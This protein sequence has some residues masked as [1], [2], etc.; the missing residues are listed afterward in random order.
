MKRKGI[1]ILFAVDTSKSML[2]QDVK[3]D[4]L[5]RAKLAVTDLVNKL[6]GDRVGLIAFAGGAFLQSPLTLDYDAFRQS[7][8]ALDTTVIPRGGTDVASAIHEAQRTFGTDSKNQKILVLITD[9][10]D[11]EAQGVQAAGAAAKEGLKIFAVGVGSTTG[12]LIPVPSANGGTEFVKDATGKL[13]KSHLDEKSLKE[14]AAATGGLYE[15]LGQSGEGL[16]RIYQQ[17]LAPLPKQE[18]MSRRQ[19]IYVERFQWPLLAGLACLLLELLIGTRK[20]MGAAAHRFVPIPA[21]QRM[22]KLRP[23]VA[24]ALGLMA[25]PAGLRASPQSAEKAYEKGNFTG[26]QQQYA[27]AARKNP[28]TPVLQFNLGAAAY[29]AGQ[30]DEAATAF[31]KTL[32]GEKIG[33]QQLAYYN[34]GN[35][36][37]RVGQKSVT[38]KPEETIKSWQEALQSYEAALKLK[39]DDADAKF[40]RDLVKKKLEEL[41]KKQQQK[42]DE[43]QKKNQKDQKDQQQ[44][45]DQQQGQGNEDQKK[46]K[47]QSKS[48]ERNQENEKPGSPEKDKQ[49]ESKPE[50]PQSPGNKDEKGGKPD[51]QQA[52]GSPDEKPKDDKK[53]GDRQPQLAKNESKQPNEQT[54]PGESPQEEER[55]RPGEMSKQEAKALLDSLQKG[56]RRLPMSSLKDES[57]ASQEEPR[58][59]DW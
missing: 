46:Q 44:K 22:R 34:L 19:K 35:T 16:E 20:R 53:P 6:D 48:G 23:A 49:Q 29:K 30:Y 57:R 26:S 56:D 15:P 13:V 45:S 17:A 32:P 2:A 37:F 8:D 3:P 38:A 47:D 54:K 58:T 21:R 55:A 25:L 52:A 11:L 5:T 33:M 14:I 12:E 10:E 24:V 1:D 36:Q 39:P 51:Q 28:N 42:Q 4:R 9:G 7:L 59:K 40:N 27:E 41:Q 18:L 50:Q 31:Q 43:Q